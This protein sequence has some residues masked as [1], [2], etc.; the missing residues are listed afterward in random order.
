MCR[1]CL[2]GFGPVVLDPCGP[3][4]PHLLRAPKCMYMFSLI[5]FSFLQPMGRIKINAMFFFLQI[6]TLLFYVII[7]M[8]SITCHSAT[9]VIYLFLP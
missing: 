5:M 6:L 7:F 1:G 3:V 4:V 9:N 2:V 8:Y